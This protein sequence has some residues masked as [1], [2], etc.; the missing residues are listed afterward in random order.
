MKK[1]LLF[2]FSIFVALIATI[3][4]SLCAKP[5]MQPA[6]KPANPVMVDF[7]GAKDGD[8]IPAWAKAFVEGDDVA[9]RQSLSLKSTD[10]IYEDMTTRDSFDDL[11][12]KGKILTYVDFMERM[13]HQVNQ[14]EIQTVEAQDKREQPEFLASSFYGITKYIESEVIYGK[15]K[16]KEDNFY[17][18]PFGNMEYH[19]DGYTDSDTSV[20]NINENVTK[21][22]VT[23]DGKLF[24]KDAY[25]ENITAQYENLF[26]WFRNEGNVK[27]NQFWVKMKMPDG[28]MEYTCYTVMSMSKENFDMISNWFLEEQLKEQMEQEAIAEQLKQRMKL[29]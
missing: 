12:L 14:G 21:M 20:S 24:I 29:R 17:I 26:K 9:L 15:K 28:K 25:G 2:R 22:V 18:T 27:F 16:I 19:F 23:P 3:S 6:P 11:L 4:S 8:E 10:K 13:R 1:D 7:M 5:K